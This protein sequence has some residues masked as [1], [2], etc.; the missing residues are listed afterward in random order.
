MTRA[1]VSHQTFPQ[2]HAVAV[3]AIGIEQAVI[4]LGDR[5]FDCLIHRLLTKL[6]RRTLRR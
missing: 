4:R 1:G 2:G 6:R 5:P 3:I